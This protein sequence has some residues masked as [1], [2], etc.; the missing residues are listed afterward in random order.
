MKKL[1]INLGAGILTIYL[2]ALLIP[3]V[4]IEGNLGKIL[5]TS[6]W[7]GFVLGIIN[8]FF[9]PL[10][11]LITFPLAILTFGLF[12]LIINIFII[13]VVDIIF[14][15]LVITGLWSLFLVACLNWI[16][17]FILIKIK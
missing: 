2:A 4:V 6:L 1:L 17:T 13:W 12:W 14:E 5:R 3:G 7:A 8:Y 16:L 11:K 9:K 15:F 10:I